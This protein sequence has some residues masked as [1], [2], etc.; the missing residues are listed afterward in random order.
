MGDIFLQVETHQGI[1]NT[2]D[3]GSVA[4][5]INSYVTLIVISQDAGSATK[6]ARYD[7]TSRFHSYVSAATRRRDNSTRRK[8]RPWIGLAAFSGGVLQLLVKLLGDMDWSTDGGKTVQIVLGCTG[9]VTCE[10]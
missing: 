4:Q 9:S 3:T 6:A 1:D 2:I 8:W 5:A 7:L 10:Q